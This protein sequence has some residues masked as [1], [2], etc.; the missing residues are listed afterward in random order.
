[1]LYAHNI[2]ITVFCK[3]EDD[4][5]KIKGTLLGLVPFDL[6]K[7]KIEF[8][9]ENAHIV[10]DRKMKILEIILKKQKH[11]KKNTHKKNEI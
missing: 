8:K 10:E 7:D 1:M 4:E 6:I 11:T 9:T 3:P 5:E 2:H